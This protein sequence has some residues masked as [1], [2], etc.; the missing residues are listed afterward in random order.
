M[1]HFR[2]LE[3]TITFPVNISCCGD[4]DVSCCPNLS[5]YYDSPEQWD[6]VYQS[7]LPCT[8]R[9]SAAMDVVDVA[10]ARRCQMEGSR[11]I[12]RAVRYLRGQRARWWYVTMSNCN[13]KSVGDLHDFE[14]NL[15]F[16]NGEEFSVKHFSADEV[17]ILEGSA[18]SL[19]ACF[20]LFITTCVYTKLLRERRLWHSTFKTLQL[21]L[22]FYILHLALKFTHFML[23]GLEG[24][25]PKWIILISKIS[26]TLSTTCF[27]AL[28]LCLS[29]G[30]TVVTP[31]LTICGLGAVLTFTGCF[32]LIVSICILW[33][34]IV[35]DPAEVLYTYQSPP[36]YLLAAIHI[37][38]WFYFVISCLRT[39]MVHRRKAHF[40]ISLGCF[41]SL[42]LLA[43]P[44]ILMAANT[45]LQAWIRLKTVTL[46]EQAVRVAGYIYMVV[47]FAPTQTN[48][49]FPFH[50]RVT[51]VMSL[52][53]K[54]QDNN[55]TPEL[56]SSAT[57]M[58]TVTPT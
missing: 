2:K 24:T 7:G 22:I 17:G 45:T 52:N 58:F 36:G 19:M 53:D 1:S 11:W 40:Y 54:G 29:S 18:V 15:V 5:L 4:N 39:G 34:S 26:E 3:Y 48:K 8:T 16:T 49:H 31:S 56:K 51:Q 23:I 10:P 43:L 57:D 32:T 47:V 46:V 35:F 12:C 27:L 42:W 28:L 20:F 44:I 6:T 13:R 25:A 55:Y 38:I 41:F 37:P 21:S 50:L 14:Y 9:E 33:E 30:F